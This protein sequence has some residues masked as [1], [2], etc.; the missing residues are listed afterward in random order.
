MTSLRLASDV[1]ESVDAQLVLGSEDAMAHQFA[2]TYGDLFRH[3]HGMGWMRCL[4]PRLGACQPAK[5]RARITRPR[6]PV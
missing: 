3:T 4:G 1:D 2:S 6:C 5:S